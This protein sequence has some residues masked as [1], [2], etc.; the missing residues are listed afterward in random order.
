[1]HPERRAGGVEPI[2]RI[3]LAVA[4]ALI[5]VACFL[6]FMGRGD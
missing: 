5:G 1:L 2:R 6:A 4:I 3:V